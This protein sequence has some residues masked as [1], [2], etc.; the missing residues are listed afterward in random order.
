M[1]SKNTLGIIM[2]LSGISAY[3]QSDAKDIEANASI[4]M[5]VQVV[6][7]TRKNDFVIS[8]LVLL[9]SLVNVSYERLLNKDSGVGLDAAFSFGDKGISDDDLGYSHILPYYRYY[10]GKKYASGFY[11]SGIVGMVNY[12]YND[13]Q[14]AIYTS[15]GSYYY[16]EN[17]KTL[18]TGT[19]GFG[20]G[21]KWVVKNNIILDAGTTITRNFNSDYRSINSTVMLGI[22][23]RF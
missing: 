15:N 18:S 19:A 8:P 21:A 7:S 10:F 22:G 16:P 3:G 13:Y 23:K 4:P 17:E 14:T 11:F 12:K 5:E 2:I 1:I 20:V 9:A 6:E